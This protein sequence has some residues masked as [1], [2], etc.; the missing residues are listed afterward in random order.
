VEKKN[1]KLKYGL[2]ETEHNT[3]LPAESKQK[4]FPLNPNFDAFL[5]E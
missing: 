4:C 5:L 3:Y 2:L 1:V